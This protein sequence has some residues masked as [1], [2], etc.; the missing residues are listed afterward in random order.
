M[1]RNFIQKL[2]F[3]FMQS[4]QATQVICEWF[5]F[6]FHFILAFRLYVLSLFF[7]KRLIKHDPEKKTDALA[8]YTSPHHEKSVKF[9]H[10]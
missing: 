3:L 9:S 7:L 4:Q 1:R 10:L 6:H 5:F 8:M 2:L